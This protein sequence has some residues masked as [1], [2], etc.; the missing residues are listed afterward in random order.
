MPKGL[1]GFQKGHKDFLSAENRKKVG[2]AVR[3]T[4]RPDSSIRMKLFNLTLVRTPK[5]GFQKGNKIGLGKAPRLGMKNSKETKLKQSLSHK[6]KI[7]LNILRGDLSGKNH[8]SWKGGI[9]PE[10]KKIRHS[11]EYR[12]WR[13]AVFER[14]NY[15]CQ[16]CGDRGVTLHADHIKPFAYYPE[17]R[18]VISNGRTLCR[19]CHS[20]TDT[21]CGKIYKYKKQYESHI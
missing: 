2:D 3:G 9:T 16:E 19:P 18:L 10:N 12:D 1:Q 11:V 4:K 7:P 6:G 20:K 21:Y 15:T 5:M 14:D 8:H 13:I 17:L